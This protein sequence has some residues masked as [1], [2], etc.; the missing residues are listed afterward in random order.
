MSLSNFYWVQL[1]STD[2]AGIVDVLELTPT[3]GV[4]LR[5]AAV[6]LGQVNVT[7]PTADEKLIVSWRR[8]YGIAGSGGTSVIISPC[9]PKAA[10]TNTQCKAYNTTVASGGIAIDRGPRHTFEVKTGFDRTYTPNESFEAE[11]I[12]VLRL[13]VAPLIAYKLTGSVLIEEVIN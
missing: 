4:S 7:P 6:I 2:V 13:E 8:G 1:P 11:G 3:T 10:G 9:R 5:V 12:L